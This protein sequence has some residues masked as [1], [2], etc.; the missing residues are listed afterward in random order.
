ML[1]VMLPF[2]AAACLAACATPPAQVT[3]STSP[4]IPSAGFG[5]V[6]PFARLG[7]GRFAREDAVGIALARMAALGV[8]S[9]RRPAR[10]PPAAG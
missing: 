5:Q 3:T 9:G 1:R 6:P 4:Q 10:H 8:P 7:Y 2:A